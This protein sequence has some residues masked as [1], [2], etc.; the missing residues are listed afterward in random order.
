MSAKLA[1]IFANGFRNFACVGDTIEG[2][3]GPFRLVATLHD[4]GDNTPPDER[5][6]GF[7]PSLNPN[8]PGYIGA[9]SESTLARHTRQ[10]ADVL[11]AWKD[12]EWHYVGVAVQVFVGEVALTDEYGAAL[13]GIEMNYPSKRKGNPNAYLGEV[14]EQLTGEALEA[15]GERL[16]ALVAVADESRAMFAAGFTAGLDYFPDERPGAVEQWI[17]ES[18][19]AYREAN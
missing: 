12:D 19:E 18:F 7:W 15:A 4:D 1:N 11:Q 14:A 13:W 9:K 2:T 5:Q 17:A 10:A 3:S 6:D 8:D 16:S